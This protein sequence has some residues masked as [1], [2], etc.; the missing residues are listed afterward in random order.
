M[1][2]EIK[3]TQPIQ[4]SSPLTGELRKLAAIRRIDGIKD[5]K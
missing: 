5:I 3:E 2:I 1:V 4:V